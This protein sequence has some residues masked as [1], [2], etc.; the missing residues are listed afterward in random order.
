VVPTDATARV[1]GVF[2]RRVRHAGTLS[3]AVSD[4]SRNLN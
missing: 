3:P 1:V 2:V 4:V